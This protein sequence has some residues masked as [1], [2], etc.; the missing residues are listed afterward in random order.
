MS[1]RM[2]N[3]STLL[4][5]TAQRRWGS[6]P[7][8][9]QPNAPWYLAQIPHRDVKNTRNKY[10]WLG[11]GKL[12]ND[13]SG[14]GTHTAALIAGETYGVAKS[15]LILD[16]KVA[17]NGLGYTSDILA[18]FNFAVYDMR[19]TIDI[20]DSVVLLPIDPGSGVLSQAIDQAATSGTVTMI[21]TKA[22]LPSQKR[23]TSSNYGPKV[24]LFAPGDNILSAWKSPG[25][26]QVL[27]S[28]GPAAA[29]VAGL[30]CLLK[31]LE[32]MDAQATKWK[33]VS[34]ATKSV[35]DARGAALVLYNGSDK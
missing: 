5:A 11:T 1:G 19:R 20:P 15:A 22:R 26:I 34:L 24:S 27:S 14:H 32:R 16:V 8:Y 35:A 17:P 23:L 28:T 30:V 33:L 6:P 2:T 7:M 25:T 3:E 9:V 4:E 18:G 29:Q 10:T 31:E 12:F 13:R 21:P